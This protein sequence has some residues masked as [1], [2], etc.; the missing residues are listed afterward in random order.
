[1]S[2]WGSGPW[3]YG[4]WGLGTGDPLRLLSAQAI[5]ENVVE[6]VF[7]EMPYFSQ[8]LEVHD[9]SNPRR[10]Q[11]VELQSEGRDGLTARPVRPVLVEVAKIAESFGRVL[12]V[13][14][15][16][17]MS[18]TPSRY[19]MVVNQLVTSAGALLDSSK[20]S[21]EF[22]GVYRE[23]RPQSMSSPTPSR[24]LA[25]PQTYSAQLDPIPQA[26]DPLFLG[27]I[28]IDASGDYAFDDGITQLKKRIF[29]RLLTKPGTFPANPEYGIGVPS[30]GK[31]LAIAGV[32]QKLASEA[33]KQIAA[34][35]DVA[36]VS[37]RVVTDAA[38]PSVTLFQI[39]VRPAGSAGN[40]NF[41]VPFAPV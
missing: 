12:H 16:R 40:V 29:R 35:P 30:Y 1:M 33:Q 15:D 3:G 39:R 13:T 41:D 9:A 2:G 8:T 28:P 34:E 10:Y 20:T 27:V 32:R 18:P 5:K 7:N 4:A 37:V 14:V 31:R 25:N 17:P 24:D 23:L 19:R 36:A 38:N 6:L 21:S 26:G 11:I 22:L